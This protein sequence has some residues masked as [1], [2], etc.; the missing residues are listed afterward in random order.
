MKEMSINKEI[1]KWILGWVLK[2][3]IPLVLLGIAIGLF[4]IPSFVPKNQ[5]LEQAITSCPYSRS[6]YEKDVF[7]C[8]NMA[9]MMD[10]WLEEEYG[11][12]TFIVSWRSVD[13]IGGHA[14][15]IVNGRFVEP[16]TKSIVWTFRTELY[17]NLS[18]SVTIIDDAERLPNYG[19]EDWL[20]EWSYPDRW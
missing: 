10:D 5:T 11:Y 1:S 8:S 18:T 7:D 20:R 16:T 4:I 12:E 14:M 3:F 15:V 17:A 9:N 6:E 2:S 13:I 19:T